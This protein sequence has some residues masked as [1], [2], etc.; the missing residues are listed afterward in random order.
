MWI[1]KDDITKKF[2]A[3]IWLF[4]NVLGK[5]SSDIAYNQKKERLKKVLYDVYGY[6]DIFDVV[7][8]ILDQKST[9]KFLNTMFSYYDN[10]NIE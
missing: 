9:D 4:E 2:L 1:N 7:P 5:Y 3:N 8:P 10:K 6:K